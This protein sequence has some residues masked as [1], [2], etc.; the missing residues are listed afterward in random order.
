MWDHLHL[1]NY[2]SIPIILAQLKNAYYENPKDPKI[3][4]HLGFVYLWN[5]CERGRKKSNPSI[6][7][8][9]CLSNHFF[10][11]AIKLNSRDPRIYGFQSATEICEGAISENPGQIAKGYIKGL[12]A[13][14]RWP[15]FNRFALSFI[16]SQLDTT[17]LLY[18]QG[19]KFQWQLIDEC[20]CKELSKKMILASPETIF[21]ALIKELQNSSDPKVKRACWNSWI[22]PH[23]F[24][25]FLLNFGDMLVKQGQTKEAKEI[26]AAAKL[27]PS[28]N[29]WVYK[30]TI[31]E[32]IKNA[33]I[34]EKIFN[35]KMKLIFPR[36]ERQLFINSAISCVACHQMSR[37]EFERYGHQEPSDEIYFF[38]KKTK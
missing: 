19:M 16:E 32:R 33:E 20:S 3:T 1:G 2:D 10:K 8:S 25:G 24:E 23:N 36:N 22:A 14:K 27:S 38:S 34:N 18:K 13:I 15:Q 6:V 21:T 31:D 12:A 28:F 11:K 4:A 35:K 37:E 26:Y 17:S 7:K 29:D 30:N 9:I 5:F